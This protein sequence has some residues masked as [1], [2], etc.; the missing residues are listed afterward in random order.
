MFEKDLLKPIPKVSEVNKKGELVLQW[1]RE[2][3]VYNIEK[4][5]EIKPFNSDRRL[6]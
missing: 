5:F 6:V 3:V 4:T 2:M 1:S